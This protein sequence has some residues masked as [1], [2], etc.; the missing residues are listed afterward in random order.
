M[1]KVMYFKTPL[2]QSIITQR[3]SIKSDILKID[4]VDNKSTLS[5]SRQ[6]NRKQPQLELDLISIDKKDK[7][8]SKEIAEVKGYA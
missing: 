4:K 8:L 6:I 7:L 1:I 5:L 3:V 2:P